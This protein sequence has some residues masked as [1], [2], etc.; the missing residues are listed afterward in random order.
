MLQ[1]EHGIPCIGMPGTIDNDIGGTD[2]TIGYDTALNTAL[3]AVDRIR[4][5]AESHDRL[6][7]VEVMGRESGFIAIMAA[8][9]GGAEEV[10]LPETKATPQQLVDVLRSGRERGKTSSIVIVCEGDEEGGALELAKKVEA[11]S[12]FHDTRVAIIG[13]L[14]RGGTPTAFDRILAARLGVRAVEALLEGHS[15]V[16]TGLHN[17]EVVLS[18]FAAAWEQRTQF[19]SSFLRIHQILAS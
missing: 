18:P 17:D 2:F 15:N 12:E 5:T 1:N 7:F 4:D 19:N 11:I 14:Q 16:M 3:D 9:A 13:H 6:F 8:I 10:M